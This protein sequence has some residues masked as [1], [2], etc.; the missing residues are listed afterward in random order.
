[1]SPTALR[2]T[3]FLMLVV[4]V[5]QISILLQALLKLHLHFMWRQRTIFEDFGIYIFRL[6]F[7]FSK[8]HCFQHYSV[9]FFI[10]C[11]KCA[12]LFAEDSVMVEFVR[13]VNT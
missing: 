12:Y 3:K 8:G 4:S 1:M 5:L 10:S 7:K 9:Y 11:L 13:G 2:Q 6:K